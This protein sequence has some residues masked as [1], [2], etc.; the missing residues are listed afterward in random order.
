MTS[1]ID[2]FTSSSPSN[3]NL[4]FS[5]SLL[6]TEDIYLLIYLMNKTG[7][8]SLSRRCVSTG[9]FFGKGCFFAFASGIRIILV[10]E[11]GEEQQDQLDTNAQRPISRLAACTVTSSP[12]EV[13]TESLG[14]GKDK[15]LPLIGL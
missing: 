8:D 9:C 13:L 2:G 1:G 15:N 6:G 5:T 3:L 11:V 10:R 14:E 12:V 7:A 4:A